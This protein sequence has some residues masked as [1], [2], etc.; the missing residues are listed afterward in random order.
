[1][2][3]HLKPKD[4]SSKAFWDERFEKEERFEWLSDARAIVDNCTRIAAGDPVSLLHVGCGTSQLSNALR[5]AMPTAIIANI[6]YSPLALERGRRMETEQF[7]SSAMRWMTADLLDSNSLLGAVSKECSLPFDIIVE[8][9]CADAISCGEDV[10]LSLPAYGS[11]TLPPTSVMALNLSRIARHGAKWVALS[12]SK[13]R[14]DVLDPKQHPNNPAARAICCLWRVV[15]TQEVEPK[16]DRSVAVDEK[17]RDGRIV[18]EPL[19][20]HTLYILERTSAD[21]QF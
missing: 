4:F 11:T 12:Y 21:F 5:E 1:M 17:P 14:F 19:I 13:Y 16:I 18:H 20:F 7:G 6:D 8:K 3:P 15:G 9:S 10:A 2:H